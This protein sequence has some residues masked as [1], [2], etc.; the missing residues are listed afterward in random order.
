MNRLIIL[1]NL[2]H[3]W[4]RL[5]VIGAAHVGFIAP[6]S[7][8]LVRESPSDFSLFLLGFFS[9]MA[10]SWI[11]PGIL[12]VRNAMHLDNLLPVSRSQLVTTQWFLRT[13][14]PATCLTCYFLLA[15]L[16]GLTQAIEA[17]MPA[18]LPLHLF[19][20]YACGFSCVFFS[21]NLLARHCA[22][23]WQ[24]R[25]GGIPLLVSS[26]IP[27]SY[28]VLL[29]S[30]REIAVVPPIFVALS[31]LV[32][33]V[34]QR[35]VCSRLLVPAFR[36]ASAVEEKDAGLP[37]FQA[38]AGGFRQLGA[39]VLV[40]SARSV[41]VLFVVVALMFWL[42]PWADPTDFMR[43][44]ATSLIPFSCFFGSIAFIQPRPERA[45]DLRI[46]RS[47]PLGPKS[48]AIRIILTGSAGPMATFLCL[49]PLAV[50]FYGTPMGLF[51]LDVSIMCIAVMSVLSPVMLRFQNQWART[52][53]GVAWLV[54]TMILL[55]FVFNS[56]TQGYLALLVVANLISFAVLL[57]SLWVF[58]D[59]LSKSSR[60]YRLRAP[61]EYSV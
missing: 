43:L 16:L 45:L 44:L 6:V 42:L 61:E 19:A 49:T 12:P 23:K 30:I 55:H 26:L 46:L 14:Y 59:M 39:Q 27:S 5:V 29:F 37:T 57:G 41:A 38:V 35:S 21:H 51:L 60:I 34:A 17:I 50:W 8:F 20:A 32:V 31:L 13:I 36:R 25:G 11:K 33:L 15:W 10:G 40:E 48:L 22:G 28:L 3:G 53:G 4:V 9:M 52:L 1:D 58:Q 54:P 18:Y 7:N 24:P 47:L 2:R 56:F